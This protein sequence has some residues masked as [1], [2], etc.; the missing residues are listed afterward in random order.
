MRS[1][2]SSLKDEPSA[3]WFES[4]P[5]GDLNAE[6]GAFC[7]AEGIRFHDLVE[8]FRRSGAPP[9]RSALDVWH[10]SV[11]GH[12]IA[13]AGLLPVLENGAGGGEDH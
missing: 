9:E 4:Y 10:L 12:R 3:G 1:C 8:D 6:I 5:F 11:E 13:A 7:R 2:R